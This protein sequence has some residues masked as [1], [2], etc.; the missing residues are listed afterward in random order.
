MAARG[1]RAA[2]RAD[3]AHWDADVVDPGRS[4]QT[5]CGRIWKGRLE[6]SGRHLLGLEGLK[7]DRNCQ[8]LDGGP[9]LAAALSRGLA[10]STR[11]RE[12][13]HPLIDDGAMLN[14]DSF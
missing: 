6:D 13:T 4:G 12:R 2:V 10:L 9:V 8:V 5:S 14:A 1:R 7:K 3:A 11:P